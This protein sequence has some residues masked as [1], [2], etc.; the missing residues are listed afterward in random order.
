M[1]PLSKRLG[2]RQHSSNP[3]KQCLYQGLLSFLSW[4]PPDP[5]GLEEEPKKMHEKQ[6]TMN[7]NCMHSMEPEI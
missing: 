4:Y 2:M 6:D 3:E 1:E 7:T 5:A